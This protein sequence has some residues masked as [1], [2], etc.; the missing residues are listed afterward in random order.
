[1][2]LA[3]EK[4][5]LPALL[6]DRG[7]PVDPA[8]VTYL[9]GRETIVRRQDGK[10]LSWLVESIVSFLSRNSSEAVDYFRLPRE[11][12]VEIGRQFAI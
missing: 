12:A 11:T 6:H 3:R 2:L 9:I 7:F 5:N 4:T 1:V 10:G 8:N